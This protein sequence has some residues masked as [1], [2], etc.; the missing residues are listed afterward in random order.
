MRKRWVPG[1]VLC[2]FA[3]WIVP[4]A[5]REPFLGDL[6]EESG[7]R[8][9]L[10]GR[11]WFV[12]Q[13]ALSTPALVRWRMRH[14]PRGGG[15]AALLGVLGALVWLGA[16]ML[17]TGLVLAVFLGGTAAL[18]GM[19]AMLIYE[20]TPF[21]LL[22]AVTLLGALE[23]A[24]FAV[25]VLFFPYERLISSPLVWIVGGVSFILYV[26][27]WVWSRRARPEEWTRWRSAI[28]QVG[29][30][31]FLAFRHIPDLDA[32]RPPGRHRH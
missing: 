2:R 30:V 32:Q 31:G 28:D 16:S 21:A 10:M 8:G 27:A 19:A 3:E 24:V 13:L 7:G 14:S 20:R 23:S 17:D 1:S 6:M 29:V 15:A 12:A 5:I 4:E 25:L 22:S 18:N 11:V 26:A 9:P